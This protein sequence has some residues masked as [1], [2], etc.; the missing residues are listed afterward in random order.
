M[1]VSAGR[2]HDADVDRN[3]LLGSDSPNLLLLE[4]TEQLD[5]QVNGH[6]A[7]LVE[8]DRPSVSELE[9]AAVSPLGPGKRPPLVAEQLAFEQRL[10]DRAAVHDDH[11]VVLAPAA[12]VDRRC[13]PLLSDT[14][15]AEEQNRCVRSA[16]A[17]RRRHELLHRGTR[18]EEVAEPQIFAEPSRRHLGDRSLTEL[19]ED[20]DHGLLELVFVRPG[21]EHG[22]APSADQRGPL[23][24]AL[25]RREIDDRRR[26]VAG[27]ELG[28]SSG[29]VGAAPLAVDEQHVGQ[30]TV[31]D[32]ERPL[33]R[34]G[35]QHAHPVRTQPTDAL[36]QRR[37]GHG[38]EQLDE[39][40]RS[41]FCRF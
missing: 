22:E 2:S 13:H 21:I 6:L 29:D 41:M 35:R 26:A 3:R 4:H 23:V 20:S 25:V 10:G 9:I 24:R 31:E 12:R 32:V 1:Q 8:E 14:G 17:T 16:H 18:R 34:V 37:A 27:Q 15:L 28:D 19:A 39:H 40:R 38:N 7:D 33:A 30:D 36:A 11:R 5:L